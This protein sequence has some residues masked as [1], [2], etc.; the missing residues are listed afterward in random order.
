[1]STFPLYYMR[2]GLGERGVLL[3]WEAAE[4]ANMRGSLGN[5]SNRQDR[6]PFG[7]QQDMPRLLRS[8]FTQVRLGT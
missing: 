7:V 1:M 8:I 6:L 5:I 4:V 2:K 3:T